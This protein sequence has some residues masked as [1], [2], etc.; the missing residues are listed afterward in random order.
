[1]NLRGPATPVVQGYALV[2]GPRQGQA[3]Y[4]S[5]MEVWYLLDYVTAKPRQFFLDP[6][7]FHYINLLES[8]AKE[9]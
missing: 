3:G 7:M 5:P 4:R 2:S 9:V 1:M 6:F 8:P